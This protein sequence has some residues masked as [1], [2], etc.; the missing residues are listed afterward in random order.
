MIVTDLCLLLPELRLD[1]SS[2]RFAAIKAIHG[3]KETFICRNNFL[4]FLFI[5]IKSDFP[6]IST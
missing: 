3:L 2:R 1:N 5:V 6:L 4:L